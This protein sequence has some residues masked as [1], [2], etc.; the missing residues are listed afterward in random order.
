[1]LPPLLLPLPLSQRARPGGTWRAQM[2]GGRGGNR[3]TRPGGSWTKQRR[4][5]VRPKEPLRS[6]QAPG[7]RLAWPC[8][9]GGCSL[10]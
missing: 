8:W 2:P 3:I 1:M 9:G 6:L 10:Q 5:M 4:Q 7:S